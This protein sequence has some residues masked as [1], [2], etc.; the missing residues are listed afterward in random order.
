LKLEILGN[1]HKSIHDIDLNLICEYY[2]GV[3]RQGPGSPEVTLKALSFIDNQ[4]PDLDRLGAAC[5][6]RVINRFWGRIPQVLLRALTFF[7]PL[8]IY[9]MLMQKD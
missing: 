2:S 1:E 9:L 8:L 3:E 7:R 4:R 5:N 6:A